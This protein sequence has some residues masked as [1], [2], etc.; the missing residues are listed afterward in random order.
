VA[1]GAICALEHPAAVGEAF[2]IASPEPI[3]YP[4]AAQVLA[5][6]LGQEILEYQAPVCW[7]YDLDITKARTWIGYDP[8]WGIREMIQD[9]LAVQAG[10]SD[11]MS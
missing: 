8:Q 6:A 1:Q 3:P 7:V 2:N 10:E 11:G 9:A 5:E 4:E